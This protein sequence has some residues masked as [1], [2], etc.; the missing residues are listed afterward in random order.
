MLLEQK[1]ASEAGATAPKARN[2]APVKPTL[3]HSA[4]DPLGTTPRQKESESQVLG[5]PF[6][7]CRKAGGYILRAQFETFKGTTYLD[8]RQWAERGGDPTRTGKGATI[9]LERVRELGEALSRVRLPVTF[10]PLPPSDGRL[11]R[12]SDRAWRLSESL[13]ANS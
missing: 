3:V 11:I 8:I 1:M 12:T 6:F 10:R 7:E 9:P 4:P 5:Q 2:V 13:L